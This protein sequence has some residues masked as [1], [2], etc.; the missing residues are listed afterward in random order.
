MMRR[1]SASAVLL[2]AVLSGP[3]A[4]TSAGG[5]VVGAQTATP[6]AAVRDDGRRGTP[7]DEPRR[8]LR[9]VLSD[10][11]FRSARQASWQGALMQRVRKWLLKL[12]ELAQPVLGRRS[13]AQVVAWAA[14]IAA[15]AVLLVWLARYAFRRRAETPLTV[16]ATSEPALPGHVL[17][18]QAAALIRAGRLREG[19]RA[20]Y[21]AAVRRLE[22][23]GAIRP[24]AARTPRETLHVLTPSHRVAAPMAALTS[25]F[26]RLWYGGRAAAEDEGP[27]LLSLLRELKCLPFDRAN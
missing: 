2:A 17:A 3:F 8:V 23:E 14:S 25:A 1:R 6:P 20:A 5:T 12:A 10:R 18:A 24:D 21:A 9:E 7:A 26:E 4:A 15:V 13:L 27:R 22:E 16:A 11:R 19:A